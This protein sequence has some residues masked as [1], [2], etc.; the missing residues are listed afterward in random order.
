MRE[1]LKSS[2]APRSSRP[3]SWQRSLSPKSEFLDRE[4]NGEV[5]RRPLPTQN[6]KAIQMP[7]KN[8]LPV[9]TAAQ[10]PTTLGYESAA[11]YLNSGGM[12]AGRPIRFDGKNGKFVDKDDDAAISPDRDFVLIGD[13]AWAGH[14]KFH[15]DGAPEHIGSLISD[16][17]FRICAREELGDNDPSLWP[18]SKFGNGP[19]DPWKECIYVPLEDRATG[20]LFTLQGTQSPTTINALKALLASYQR[21]AQ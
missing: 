14:I 2:R 5:W 18:A 6:Q 10:V 13:Q 21:R 4:E 11:A 9:K 12:T 1:T 19:E 20:E 7:I 3:I 17:G 15:E 8:Q 16:S